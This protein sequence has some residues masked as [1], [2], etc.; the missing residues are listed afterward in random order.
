MVWQPAPE[1]QFSPKHVQM[2]NSCNSCLCGLCDCGI[3][4]VPARQW[5]LM[6]GVIGNAPM[7]LR[8]IQRHRAPPF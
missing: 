5:R 8:A 3:A 2:G 7:C 6:E 1:F 4:S